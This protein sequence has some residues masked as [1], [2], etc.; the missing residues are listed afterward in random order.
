ML[1][2]CRKLLASRKGASAVEYGLICAMIVVAAISGASALGDSNSGSWASLNN[3]VTS[4]S[5]R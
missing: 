4:V 3:R 2:F 1:A 5:P